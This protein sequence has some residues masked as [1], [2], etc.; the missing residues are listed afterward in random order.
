MGRGI[1]AVGFEISSEAVD[2]AQQ[3]LRVDCR[4]GAFED[5]RNEGRVGL[6]CAFHVLEHVP[7][8]L[9]FVSRGREMLAPGGWLALEV[10]NFASAAAAREGTDWQGLQP[11]Y[12]RWHFTS[13]TLGRLVAE[14][15]FTVWQTDTVFGRFYVPPRRYLRRWAL[16]QLRND[17]F[18]TRSLHRIHAHA[19]DNI[20]LLARS[21]A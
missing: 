2:F 5:Q 13:T 18:A 14:A 17:W 15:G 12:H 10:P 6:V 4:Q 1:R 11:R 3:Q 8:P 19:G 20:R 16:G 9:E 7:D 21:L